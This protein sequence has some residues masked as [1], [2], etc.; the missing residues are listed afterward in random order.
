MFDADLDNLTWQADHM[1]S[2]LQ[3]Q[4]TPKVENAMVHLGYVPLS[5]DASGNVENDFD[6]RKTNKEG[7]AAFLHVEPK[8]VY[9]LIRTPGYQ[10][11]PG[12][13]QMPHD[14]LIEPSI[15]PNA[16]QLLQADG[17]DIKAED[18][19]RYVHVGATNYLHFQRWLEGQDVEPLLYAGFDAYTVTFSMK[20]VPGQAGLP[21]LRPENYGGIGPFCQRVDEYLTWIE[22]RGKRLEATL[23]CDCRVMGVDF[24]WQESFTN[25]LY[26]VFRTGCHAVHLVQLVNEPDNGVNAVDYARFRQPSGL[27]WSRGSSLAGQ[28]CPLPAGNY[29]DAHLA[30]EG[31]GVY[32][33]AQPYYMCEGYPGYVGVKGP[34]ITNETRGA[35]NNVNS[36]S[37]TT[38]PDYF[39]RIAGAFRGWAGGTFHGD[40]IVHS[41]PMGDNIRRCADA[42]LEGIR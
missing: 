12:T 15:E 33:D 21:E 26:E 2:T 23:L 37:R 6:E 4:L 25:S 42:F 29:A 5:V 10:D 22:A 16:L 18:G 34:V 19:T 27:F 32:L 20:I 35:S 7:Y 17:W 41:R 28:A 40:D 11:Q 36:G 9:W 13:V 31:G 8:R 39:R 38:D 24:G 3:I 14:E 30:R 1:S